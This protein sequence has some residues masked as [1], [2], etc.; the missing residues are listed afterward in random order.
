MSIVFPRCAF[1]H[2]PLV[3]DDELVVDLL[4]GVWQFD[5]LLKDVADLVES[6]R[7]SPVVESAG[8]V[9]MVSRIGP[10]RRVSCRNGIA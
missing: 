7:L 10:E 8:D 2:N 9:D 4:I 3:V 5:F 1:I 6:L